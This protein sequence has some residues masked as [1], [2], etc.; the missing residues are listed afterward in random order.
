MFL[1]IVRA[2]EDKEIF[3]NVNNIWKIEVEYAER[4]GKGKMAGKV[5]L[6][7]GLKNPNAVRIYTLFV[8][9][10]VVRLEANPDDPVAQVIEKIYNES[11]KG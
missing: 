8:G 4:G 1:R 6:E 9:S 3:V 5:S 2:R 7:S 10:E 11:I